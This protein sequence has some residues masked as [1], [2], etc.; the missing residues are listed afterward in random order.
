MMLPSL[1]LSPTPT[2]ISATVPATGAGTSIVA[3][4][5]SSVMSGSSARTL[6]PAF[7]NISTIGTS[8]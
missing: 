3:L 6:S 7:T 4:S 5:D 1:T 8:A 2:T